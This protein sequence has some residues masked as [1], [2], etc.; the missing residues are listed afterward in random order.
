MVTARLLKGGIA[1]NPRGQPLPDLRPGGGSASLSGMPA[2]L[3]VRARRPGH[4]HDRSCRLSM[5]PSPARA[6]IVTP[7]AIESIEQKDAL[8]YR[9]PRCAA[10]LARRRRSCRL[11]SVADHSGRRA[12][13]RHRAVAD[14]S[15]RPMSAARPAPPMTKT[16]PGSLLHQGHH[17][18][19]LGRLRQSCGR[20][21]LGNGGTGG[22]MAAP[23]AEPII[24]ASWNVLS[25]DAAAAALDRSRSE[26]LKP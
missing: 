23:I 26:G 21:T 22:R 13:A 24:Q 10:D 1:D 17:G 15:R 5:P 9:H 3:S 18:G 7:Y 8:V 11:L 2:A 6:P 14:A 12:D 25:Q 20:R 16:M 4:P 19:G